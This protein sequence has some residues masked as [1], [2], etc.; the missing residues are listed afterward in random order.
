M[1]QK[2]EKVKR[3]LVDLSALEDL[4]SGLG[5]VALSYAKYF[6]QHY[7]RKESGYSLL[8]LVPKKLFGAFGNEVDYISSSDWF[9]KHCRFLFPKVDVWHAIHQLSR[10]KPY[11][12]ET[13]YILTVHDLNYLYEETK[14]KYI[15]TNQRR[16]QR[17]I[18]HADEIVCISEFTKTEVE[19]NMNLFGKQ[20]RVILNQVKLIDGSI[21]QKPEREIK[22]PFFFSIGVI[23]QKKN[24]HVLLDLMKK[25]PDKHLYI[26]GK[27]AYDLSKPNPYA[28]M[29][30][31]RIR[32]E[33]ITNVTLLGP[34]SNEEKIWMFRNCEAFL[35]PSLLEGFGLPVIEAMQFGKPVFSSPKTS[36]TEIGDRFAFFW[37]DF[38]ADNMKALIDENLTKFYENNQFIE[39][40]KAYAVSFSSDKHFEEYEKLYRL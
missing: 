28:A 3:V 30:K 19:K 34:I 6:Q 9:K 12:S 5:Q 15:A 8:L 26:A 38:D 24:F 14:E 11:S 37:K 22:T 23:M 29:I 2:D 16:I 32:T 10:F 36:L 25:Y 13:R 33:N 18:R 35:I 1:R 17:K 27:D 21:A 20:C 7:K 31:E 40:Q 4:Y 39:E